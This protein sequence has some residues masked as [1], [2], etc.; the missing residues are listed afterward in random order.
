MTKQN[1]LKIAFKLL[2]QD[3]YSPL[4]WEGLWALPHAQGYRIDNVP[5]YAWLVSCGDIVSA[6]EVGGDLVFDAVEAPGGHSTIRVI[7]YLD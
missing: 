5:F 2:Q 3:G 1:H 7:A 6:H 4:E